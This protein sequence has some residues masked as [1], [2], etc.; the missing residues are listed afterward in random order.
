MLSWLLTGAKIQ[1]FI[2][3]KDAKNVCACASN[4]YILF[5]LYFILFRVF[6]QIKYSCAKIK[7]W[8]PSASLLVYCFLL[9]LHKF[10]HLC[11]LPSRDSK[12]GHALQQASQSYSLVH[13]QVWHFFKTRRPLTVQGQV[14]LKRWRIVPAMDHSPHLLPFIVARSQQRF[15]DKSGE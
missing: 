12:S 15:S 11:R 10:I 4:S 14:E 5:L 3:K 1:T 6:L 13:A 7:I 2:P 8:W 9:T